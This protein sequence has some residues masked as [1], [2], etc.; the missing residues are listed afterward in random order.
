MLLDW[1]RAKTEPYEVRMDSMYRAKTEPYE[2][3]MDSMYRAKTEP[4]EVR[5]DFMY[6]VSL[7]HTLQSKYN[8]SS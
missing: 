1:C 8:T 2:V 6:N 5:M 7:I 4:Y 3:R